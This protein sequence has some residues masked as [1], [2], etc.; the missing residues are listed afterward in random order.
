MRAG[1]RQ[2]EGRGE[3][4]AG[5]SWAA[6]GWWEGESGKESEK[7]ELALYHEG[8]PNPNK[9]LGDVLID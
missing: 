7:K 8:N 1:A 9:G 6:G 2:R 5:G 4:L 3:G